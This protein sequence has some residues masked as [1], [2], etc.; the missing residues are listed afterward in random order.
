MPK[1]RS[2]SSRASARPVVFKR[3]L[4]PVDFSVGSDRALR[5]AASLALAHHARVLPLHVTPPICFTVDCGYG[6]VN[7]AVPD[8]DSL[9]QTRAQLQ[10]LVHR[11]VPAK[12]AEAVTVRSGKPIEQILMAAKEWKADLIIMLAHDAL[13]GD[14]APPT[15]TV[16][17][18]VR[19]GRC[20]V[21]LLHPPTP[22]RKADH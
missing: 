9:R 1:Y 7:R 2:P 8:E 15:H 22:L 5:H 3:I 18:L 17:R 10:R 13:G 11:I 14:S 4:V 19:E 16:D 20:P 21:L 6:P 12:L